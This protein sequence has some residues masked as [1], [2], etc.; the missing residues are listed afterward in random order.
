MPAIDCTPDWKPIEGEM[1]RYK[2]SSCDAVGWRWTYGINKGKIMPSKNSGVVKPLTAQQHAGR[3]ETGHK[4]PP[5]SGGDE[6]WR[7]K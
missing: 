5:S 6:P 1:G 7:N 4:L 3:N 2:C